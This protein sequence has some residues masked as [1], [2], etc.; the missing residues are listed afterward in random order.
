MKQENKVLGSP[1]LQLVG[2]GKKII[3]KLTA[4]RETPELFW[5]K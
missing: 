1:P 4:S 5:W 2:G 3:E